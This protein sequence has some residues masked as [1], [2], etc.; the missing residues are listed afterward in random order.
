MRSKVT[1][2]EPLRHE[3]VVV[4]RMGTAAVF[5]PLLMRERSK[6]EMDAHRA[7]PVFFCTICTCVTNV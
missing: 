5:V 3:G 1:V 2:V 7:H 6:K 4:F